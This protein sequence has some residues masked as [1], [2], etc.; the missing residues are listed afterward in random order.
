M[1]IFFFSFATVSKS[2]LIVLG[3]LPFLAPFRP[4]RP[5]HLRAVRAVLAVVLKETTLYEAPGKRQGF[6]AG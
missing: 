5:R 1:I 3:T 6:Y 4:F 2:L